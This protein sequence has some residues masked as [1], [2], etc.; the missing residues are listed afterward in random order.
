MK[1][2][3][4]LHLLQSG[5]FSGAENVTCQIISI[6]KK[7][8]RIEM[9]YCSPD[10]QIREVL[11]EQNIKHYNM[12]NFSLKEIRKVINEYQPDIIHAHDIRCSVYASF[13]K[14][15]RKIIS[16]LHGNHNNMRS[17]NIKTIL[18]YMVSKR[19]KTIICVSDS[20]KNDFRFKKVLKNAAVLYNVVNKNAIYD[21]LALDNREYDYDI[22]FLGRINKIKN[23]LRILN[24][25]RE[26]IKQNKEVKVAFIGEGELLEELRSK[27]VE[28]SLDDNIYTLGSKKNPYKILS[29][30][31]L[32]IMASIYEG[33]P[34]AALEALALGVPIVSTPVDGLKDII[35]SE[36]NGYLSNNDN[37]L[38]NVICQ[39]IENPELRAAWSHNAEVS[40]RRQCDI[41]YYKN[42]L[43]IAYGFKDER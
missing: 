24:I 35:N 16:H 2:I 41:D 38:S 11:A 5:Q 17:L 30:A 34:M 8:D 19:F 42:E 37:E 12:E 3:K 7:N 9:V 40:F 26:V 29:N 1:K 6:F 20:I 33:T 31:K 14:G 18:Y 13:F 15:K 43:E 22:V 28:Y 23:P 39:L 36:Y 27:I 32:M 25:L 10:G 21:K 4:V